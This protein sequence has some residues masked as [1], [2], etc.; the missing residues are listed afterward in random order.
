MKKKSATTSTAVLSEDRIYRYALYRRWDDAL[1]NLVW[2]G[3]NPSTAD[4]IIDDPTVRRI[5]DF[6]KAWNY[7][8]AVL[9]N[10]FGLRATDPKDLRTASDPV[11]PANDA[12]LTKLCEGHEVILAWGVHGG[13]HGRDE[14]VTD[15]LRT[16]N[17]R[18]VYCLGRT[19]GGHPKHPLYLAKK[20]PLT[21]V[22][23][24]E[25]I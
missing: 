16:A 21:E 5:V 3:L 10:L 15:L 19:K 7:G 17:P 9:L 20:T 11:G 24:T 14:T 12:A 4:E 18:Q 22:R 13:L 1:P 2:I 8:G 25:E 6:S 23:L